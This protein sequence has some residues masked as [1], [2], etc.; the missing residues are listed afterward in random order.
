MKLIWY[1]KRNSGS[2]VDEIEWFIDIWETKFGV[3]VK[4]S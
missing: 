2:Y 1:C 4:K 3:F